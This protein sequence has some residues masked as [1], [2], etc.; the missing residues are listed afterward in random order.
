MLEDLMGNVQKQQG[1]MAEK[2]AQITVET[3]SG[4]GAVTVVA[5]ADMQIRNITINTEKVAL[6]DKEQLEDL[7]VVAVNEALEAAKIK[8]AAETQKLIK[9][10][11]PF[12]DLDQFMPGK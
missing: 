9:D 4:D 6:T 2:L 8:A 1:E 11:F 3:E 12:G 5:T 7:L 10:M